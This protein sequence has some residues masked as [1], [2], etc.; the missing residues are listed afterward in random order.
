[1]VTSEL[2][3]LT[4]TGNAFPM[5]EATIPVLSLADIQQLIA[6]LQLPHDPTPVAAPFSCVPTKRG[7]QN[8]FAEIKDALSWKVTE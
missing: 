5:S 2:L 8:C 4:L 3:L 7:V 6:E 1:V